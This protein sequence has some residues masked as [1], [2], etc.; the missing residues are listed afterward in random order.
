VVKSIFSAIKGV[1]VGW[2]KLKRKG[3]VTQDNSIMN[4]K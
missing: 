1:A 2:N 3:N 4:I